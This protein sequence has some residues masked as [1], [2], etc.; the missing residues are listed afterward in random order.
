MCSVFKSGAKREK[1]HLYIIIGRGG[2]CP[3]YLYIHIP[4]QIFDAIMITLSAIR[5]LHYEQKEK[6]K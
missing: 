5:T 6:E 2:V 1:R 4:R 3:S